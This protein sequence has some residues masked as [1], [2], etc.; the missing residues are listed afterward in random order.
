MRNI[1]I[2]TNNDQNKTGD[3][4]KLMVKKNKLAGNNSTK[5]GRMW[6]KP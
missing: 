5:G 3:K 2:D 1:I 4:K 6:F